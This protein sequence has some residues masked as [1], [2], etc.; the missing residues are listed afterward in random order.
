[1]GLIKAQV[2]DDFA[3]TRCEAIRALS[4]VPTKE[5]VETVLLA[6]DKPRDYWIDYT[7]SATLSALEGVWKPLLRTSSIAT[8][9]PA[10]L[11]LLSEMENAGKPSGAATAAL[12]KFLAAPDMPEQERRKITAEIAKARGVSENGRVVF[13]RICNACHK[14]GSEGIEYGPSING[15]AARM[16]REEII[17]SILEPNAQVAAQYVTTTVETKSG[18]AFAGFVASETADTLMLKVA[19]GVTQEIKL[20][21][22]KKR[23]SQKV[24]SMPEGLAQAMSPE[25]FLDLIEF[26]SPSKAAKK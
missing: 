21:D 25:E 1:M 18:E 23:E 22:I 19:G 6:A 26:L 7:L 3:R 13:R 2:T 11:A 17:E 5:A 8:D 15:L 10:G 20:A 4:F 16:K 24:S 14:W 12:K 9:H